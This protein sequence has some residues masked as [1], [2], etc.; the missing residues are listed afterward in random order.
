MKQLSLKNSI[1]SINNNFLFLSF[2]NNK[3]KDKL[4]PYNFKL[5]K[6]Q[7]RKDKLIPSNYK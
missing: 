4:I 1:K 5:I 7:K 2:K 6:F 3:L